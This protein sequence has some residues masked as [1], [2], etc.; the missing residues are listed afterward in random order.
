MNKWGWLLVGACFVA[1]LILVGSS[2]LEA[3]GLVKSPWI[4]HLSS[5]LE[6]RPWGTPSGVV[7]L[8]ANPYVNALAGL[9]SHYLV[10]VLVLFAVPQTVRR[11]ADTLAG[12]RRSLAL[13]PF[14]GVLL[15]AMLL[16][17][18]LLTAVF[19]HLFPVPIVLLFVFFIAALS[20]VIALQF[21]LGRDL[22]RRAG[23]SGASPLAALAV[24]TL[25]VFS[26]TRVPYLGPL[27]LAAVW[28]TGVGLVLTT[29]FGSGGRWSLEPLQEDRQP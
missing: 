5:R 4:G 13:Y 26:A 27:V 24:G 9:V 2:L 12:G 6:D 16:A 17:V 1:V 20:G 3:R 29:R 7:F 10:G 28:L 22:L 15:S 11:L 8:E 21:E 23:R 19:A 14:V 25:L 18:A